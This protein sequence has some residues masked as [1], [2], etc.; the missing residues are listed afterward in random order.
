MGSI[1]ETDGASL[2]KLYQLNFETAYFLARP[3]LNI[4]ANQE[5]G[6][7]IVFVGSR[8]ALQPQEGKDMVAYSLSK[9]LV[10]HLAELIN[11]TYKGQNIKASVIVPGTMDTPRNRASMPD[12]DYSQWVPPA[13]VANTIHFLFSES[14]RMLNEPILKIYNQS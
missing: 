14:G 8:P 13:Q 4:L 9:S 12:A 1:Q 3:L 6:G 5:N 11:A 2:T 10:F 7:Q